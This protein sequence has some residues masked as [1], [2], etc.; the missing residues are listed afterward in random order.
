L[1]LLYIGGIMN[2]KNTDIFGRKVFFIA[3]D[4]MLIPLSFMEDFCTLG[5]ESHIVSRS[6]SISDSVRKIIENFP[7][8]LIFFNI[9]VSIPGTSYLQFIRQI[10]QENAEIAVGIV[11][12]ATNQEQAKHIEADYK[13]D[14]TPSAGCIALFH[15]KNK[16]NFDSIL[17]ALEKSGAKGRR[18]NIRAKCD[19]ES[20]LSFWQGSS[21]FVA[22]LDDVNIS[23]ICCI[24]EKSEN[25]RNMK[26]YD[27]VRNAHIN[28][29]GLEFNSDIVLI[30]KRVKMGIS[31]AIFMFIKKPDDEPGLET[32]AEI[33]LNKKIYEITSDE[34]KQLFNK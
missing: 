30:M 27:K 24:L 25:I 32:E 18:N 2:L 10:R 19:N 29:N 31:T 22:K 14:V 6:N 15:G 17:S 4:A 11:F 21:N 26:I 5:Y 3:P 23:H 33:K 13:N 9:D 28:V 34:F 7:D 1:L 16:E 8:A 12:S 20:H